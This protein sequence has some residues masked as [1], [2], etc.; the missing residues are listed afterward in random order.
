MSYKRR[1]VIS[2]EC[3]NL[4]STIEIKMPYQVKNRIWITDQEGTFLAEGR[5]ELMKHID[6]TGSISK[7]AKEMKM[8]YKKAWEMVDSMNKSAKKVLMVK[9]I[10]GKKGGGSQ[11]TDY[12]KEVIE[13]FEEL[14]DRSRAALDDIMKEL[15][16]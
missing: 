14:K 9:R 4:L 15:K 13:K 2:K 1:N 16:F 8:S 3:V 12:G 10:G 5:I 7:A 6:E 11:L